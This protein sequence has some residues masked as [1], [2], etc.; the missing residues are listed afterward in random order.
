[1]IGL[2]HSGIMGWVRYS[3]GRI[4]MVGYG[5]LGWDWKWENRILSIFIHSRSIFLI[6]FFKYLR[7]FSMIIL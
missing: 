1:M 4:R 5:K 7:S 2:T 6:E 3:K